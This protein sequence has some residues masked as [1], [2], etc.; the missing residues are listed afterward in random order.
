MKSFRSTC[1]TEECI[2]HLIIFFY[3]IIALFC[4]HFVFYIYLHVNQVS[5]SSWKHR[6]VSSEIFFLAIGVVIFLV[7]LIMCLK[8]C[9]RETCRD[10]C[11]IWC[12]CILSFR[13]CA[14]CRERLFSNSSNANR[15]GHGADGVST[16]G[17]DNPGIYNVSFEPPSYESVISEHKDP[18]LPSYEEAICRI[19]NLEVIVTDDT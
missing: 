11:S 9:S 5:T 4:N 2:F 7:A 3:V 14:W 17:D 19:N 16:I 1:Y 12:G 13:D 6:M 15:R 18:D 10:F 8:G